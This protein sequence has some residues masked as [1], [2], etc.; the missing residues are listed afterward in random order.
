MLDVRRVLKH[1]VK[2]G[3]GHRR[4]WWVFSLHAR[5]HQTGAGH[6]QSPEH[7]GR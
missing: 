5:R 6:L 2:L 4:R 3:T 7:P 1:K